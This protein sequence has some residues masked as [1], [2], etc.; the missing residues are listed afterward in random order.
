M[1]KEFFK[2]IYNFFF[3]DSIDVA[4]LEPLTEDERDFKYG[5]LVGAAEYIPKHEEF[6]ID[7]PYTK[8]QYPLNT[9]AWNSRTIGK[10]VD[11]GVELS[12]KYV[13]KV[14]KWLGYISGNGF[15][16]LRS[17]EL[18]VQK[19]GVC[20]ERLC[21]DN[22]HN[23]WS[24]YSASNTTEEQITNAKTH[25]S[26]SFWLI[27]NLSE[28]LQALDNGK[29]IRFGVNWCS[30]D[31][32]LK[33]PFILQFSGS[34]IGGHAVLAKGYNSKRQLI[35]F[36]NSFGKD[37]GDNGEGWIRYEDFTKYILRYGAFVDEDMPKDVAKFLNTMCGKIVK[38][39]DGPRCYFIEYN[40]KRE[41]EDEFAV[42]GYGFK[43]ADILIDEENILPLIKDGDPLLVKYAPQQEELR[44]IARGEEG[45]RIKLL[46]KKHFVEFFEDLKQ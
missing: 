40:C 39:K 3:K 18:V 33:D 10:E 1:L 29:T 6:F 46:A 14:G 27:R 35:R 26:Q 37:W 25:K 20:E 38:E 43:L 30:G 34:L 9:C 31:N 2:T 11:E 12:V 41:F 19:Y 28:A 15:T 21:P 45:G 36:K 7:T 23:N 16:N 13:V 8:D 5:V 17:P 42:W 4:G 44:E 32:N 22:Q 24:A